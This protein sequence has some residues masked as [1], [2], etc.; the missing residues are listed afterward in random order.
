MLLRHYLGEPAP[1]WSWSAR[2]ALSA[3]HPGRRTAAGRSFH[4]GAFDISASVKAY[5]A[6]KMIGDDT[7]APHMARA[8]EAI[9]AD[10]GA[11]R[12]NVFTRILLAL[13]GAVPWRAVPTM[14]V[15]IMLL[16]RWFPFHL[17]DV[18]LGA[19]RDRAAA[20]AAAP[21]PLARNPRGVRI[22]ELFSRRPQ[23][24]REWP[25]GAA[26]DAGCGRRSSAALD[27]AAADG[28][29]AV[30]EAHAPARDRRGRRLRRPSG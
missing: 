24:V 29:A 23:T 9:L 22:D 5:F 3:P 4:D 21:K 25:T 19:H 28:R 13:F 7:D 10:G 1:T 30:P 8:R 12:V 6:L 20:G 15:E 16:P 17:E 14:P 27:R 11:A 2:S 26:S 18:V